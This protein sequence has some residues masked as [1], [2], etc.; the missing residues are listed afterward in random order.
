MRVIL[1]TNILIG[2]LMTRATPPAL[3]YEAWKAGR[4]NLVSSEVQLREFARVTRYDTVKQ[5]I[6]ASEA[7][8]LINEIRALAVVIEKLPKVDDISSDPADNFLFATAQAGAADYLVTG[9][10]SG[11]LVLKR[12][13]NT[14]IITARK[15]VETLGL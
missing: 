14:R 11:V 15:M 8:T 3:L 7:G 2:A 1:D 9:D 4:F 5:F 10:K 13:K 12:H 6:T